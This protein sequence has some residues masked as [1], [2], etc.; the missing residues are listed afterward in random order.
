MKLFTV[1]FTALIGALTPRH[2][3][4]RAILMVLAA[5]TIITV[6]ARDILLGKCTPGSCDTKRHT[7]VYGDDAGSEYGEVRHRS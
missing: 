2:A 5:F 1:I 6:E 7:D 3:A 4:A